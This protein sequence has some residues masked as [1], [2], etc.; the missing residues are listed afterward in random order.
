M[1]A[2]GERA[3]LRLAVAD[4]AG[5]DQIRV[6]E[7]RPEGVHERVSELPAFVDRPRRLRRRVT[8]DPAR[9]RE[10]AEEL[11]QA[12]LALTDVRIQLAVRPLEVRVGH[13]RRPAVARAGDEDRI[14]VA[15]PDRPVQVGIDQ[16]QAGHRSEVAEQ[17][18]LHVL[19]L[20]RLTQQRIAEQVDLPHGEIVRG[21][22]VGV[23]QLELL[24]GRRVRLRRHRLH[25]CIDR[26]W[27]IVPFGLPTL[28]S[29]T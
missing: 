14:E 29:P 9:I 19:R 8:R 15:S 6:V 28:R 21:T 23:E 17:P 20:Q 18:R 26:Q 10:L 13:V 11:A 27:D 3:G 12:I 22:P 24:P 4:D 1:P 25:L 16:V 7:R 5:N 2:R